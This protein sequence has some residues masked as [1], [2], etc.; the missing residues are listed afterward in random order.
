MNIAVRKKTN[1]PINIQN[2]LEEVLSSSLNG[3]GTF[4]LT[5]YVVQATPAIME[6]SEMTG[7]KKYAASSKTIAARPVKSLCEKFFPE[8]IALIHTNKYK[9]KYSWIFIPKSVKACTEVS[10]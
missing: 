8:A 9:S 7:N 2:S 1:E 3:D 10:P 4:L 5:K 6:K